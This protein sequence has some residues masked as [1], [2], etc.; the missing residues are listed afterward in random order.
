MVIELHTVVYIYYSYLYYR[1]SFALEETGR[2]QDAS[3]AAWESLSI[4]PQAPWA[5]H[6]L[7]HVIEEDRDAS[8]GVGILTSTRD[9][10]KDSGLGNHIAWHLCLYYFGMF[11]SFFVCLLVCTMWN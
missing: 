1:Y 4:N 5:T 11:N 3:T 6:A 2:Y 9:H 7:G 8:E 10:W